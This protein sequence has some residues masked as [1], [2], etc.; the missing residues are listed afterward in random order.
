MQVGAF[1]AHVAVDADAREQGDLLAAQARHAPAAPE[2]RQ[3][4]LLRVVRA[5]AGETIKCPAGEAHWHG[6]TDTHFMAHLALVVGDG[7]GD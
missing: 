2:G 5:S 7:T 6:P 1:Q 4:R 3:S